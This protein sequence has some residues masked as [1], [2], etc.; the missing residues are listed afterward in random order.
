MARP[1]SSEG[2]EFRLAFALGVAPSAEEAALASAWFDDRRVGDVVDIFC[3]DKRWRAGAVTALAPGKLTIAARGVKAGAAASVTFV[4]VVLRAAAARRLAAAGARS[5]EPAGATKRPGD[6][7]RLSETQL[8]AAEAQMDAFLVGALGPSDAAAYLRTEL[9]VRILARC[10]PSFPADLL[11][12]TPPL[13][14]LFLG[15][16]VRGAQQQH[17]RL[18]AD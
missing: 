1:L 10:S 15:A 7:L 5:R 13:T 6:E 4:E 2:A 14:V 9:P 11:I 3:E 12:T 18:A 8:Q 16:R 17:R